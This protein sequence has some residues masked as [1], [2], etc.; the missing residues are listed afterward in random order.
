M[1]DLIDI[2]DWLPR[3]ALREALGHAY[4]MGVDNGI[5]DGRTDANAALDRC[6]TSSRG[7][8]LAGGSR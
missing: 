8:R 1:G 4:Y 5:R 3:D 6:E 2:E 7:V